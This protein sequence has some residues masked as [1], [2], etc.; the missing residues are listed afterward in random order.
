MKILVGIAPGD[1]RDEVIEL[2]LN[3]AA[4]FKARVYLTTSL[5]G[6]SSTSEKEVERAQNALE[7]A[8]AL[9][10]K[11]GIVCETFL[12]VRGNSP[13]R[14]LVEFAQEKE[15]DEIIVGARKRSPVGKAILGSVTQRVALTASC[16]VV[17][18]K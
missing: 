4:Q 17:L 7:Y 10:E 9:F 6:G 16:P 15:I 5:E 12:L 13:D 18:V 14:D 8:K 2:A 11:Q 1:V 3:H